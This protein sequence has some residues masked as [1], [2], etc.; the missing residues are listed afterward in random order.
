MRTTVELPDGL[1]HRAKL[2]AVRRGVSL[3]TLVTEALE[4]GLEAG[5]HK[6]GAGTIQF[7]LRHSQQPGSYDPS[8]DRV[9][10]L[11]RREEVAGEEVAQRR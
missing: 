3:K 8:P 9:A 10:E 6:C 4:H 7:P 2:A 11:L 5:G 1:A